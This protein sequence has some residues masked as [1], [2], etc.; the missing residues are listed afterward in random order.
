MKDKLKFEFKRKFIHLFSLLYVLLYYVLYKNYN[1]QIALLSLV[2]VLIIFILMEYFRVIKKKKIPIFDIFWRKGE[3]NKLAGYIYF[4]IGAIIV[5]SV[6]D[7]NIA[8]A[9]LLMTTFGDMA[10]AIF[11]IS[12][13]KHW[14]KSIPD[15][16]WEGIIAEFLVDIII[17]AIFI[18]NWW[19]ILAMALTATFVETV[20]THVDDNLTIPVFSGFV[21]QILLKIF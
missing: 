6:F 11:G 2:G 18:S 17:G 5:F 19:I 14:V 7:F 20:F 13:G 3:K 21:A 4:A 1:H 15:T 8:V 10:A 9:A 12:F 16:A